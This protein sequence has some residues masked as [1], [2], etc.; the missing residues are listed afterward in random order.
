MKYCGTC[1]IYKDLSEFSPR[2]QAPDGLSP[3]C[4][5]CK[6]K[7]NRLYRRRK[8]GKELTPDYTDQKSK[9]EQRKKTNKIRYKV[10][11]PMQSK[12]I[13]EKQEKSMLEK[14][15]VKNSMQK[16]EC[17][18]KRVETVKKKY[19]FNYSFELDIDRVNYKK[20][21]LEKYKTTNPSQIHIN[22]KII[23]LVNNTSKF[24]K[25]ME[26]LH[27]KQ[28]KPLY[29]IAQYFGVTTGFLYN[30]LD[31]INF[32]V[33]TFKT[34]VGQKEVFTFVRK[35]TRV[36]VFENY[37][38]N[39]FEYDI[40]IPDL[41][42][43]IEYDGNYWHSFGKNNQEE[44]KSKRAYSNKKLN[45]A[46]DSGI[47]LLTIF[48]SEWK[49]KPHIWKSIIL[50]KLNSNIKTIYARNC[51]V[52][53]VDN[54]TAKIFL[55]KNHLQGYIPSRIH[56]GLFSNNRLMSLMSFSKPR[57]SKKAD[58]ELIRF[59][60]R[61]NIKVIGGASKLIKNFNKIHKGSILTYADL[62][63]STGKVYERIGFKYLNTSSPNYFYYHMSDKSC[64]LK[65]RVQ[66][67]KHKLKKILEEFDPNLT[68][69]LNMFNH[70]YRRIWDY[71]NLVFLFDLS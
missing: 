63:Y 32:K 24:L 6:N 4:K 15:G 22:S 49:L 60:T 57:Y 35:H 43:A 50:N 26:V 21:M 61:T 31:S 8:V 13:R 12:S 59:S 54:S 14:Y 30:Y 69:A 29:V 38:L 40:Y 47:T 42:L 36:E 45:N 28:R 66:F 48:E 3:I 9:E 16:K 5:P 44:E 64:K 25:V 33:K 1:E 7:K 65:S 10:A 18:D 62:R 68:E 34:S 51:E 55:N 56:L 27:Y 37:K 58:W 19:G 67:Q 71:G 53:E 20:S 23:E 70:G 52:K 2:K 11:H 41:K 39:G 46:L 17:L